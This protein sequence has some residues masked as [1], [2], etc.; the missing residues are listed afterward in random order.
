MVGALAVASQPHPPRTPLRSAVTSGGVPSPLAAA[1]QLA[2]LSAGSQLTGGAHL[3]HLAPRP[4]RRPHRQ[5][6]DVGGSPSFPQ[7]P[8]SALEGTLGCSGLEALWLT[9]GGPPAAEVTAASVAMAESGGDQYATGPYGERGYWQINPNHGALST[10]DA[11]GNARAAITL[12]ADGG[13]WSAW[14]T[15]VDGTYLGRC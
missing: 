9:A 6:A 13:N 14:T 10:Y 15:F 4:D 3:A 12:S 11:Y 2:R 7:Q 5:Q 1:V 8:T